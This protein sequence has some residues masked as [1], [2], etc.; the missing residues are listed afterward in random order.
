MYRLARG[1]GPSRDVAGSMHNAMES[2]EHPPLSGINAPDNSL[3]M[4]GPATEPMG[5]NDIQDKKLKMAMAMVGRGM[6]GFGQGMAQNNIMTGMM[7]PPTQL[8]IYGN[9]AGGM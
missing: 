4:G 2:H 3:T 1:V 8:D 7:Q 5:V 9:Q 6:T